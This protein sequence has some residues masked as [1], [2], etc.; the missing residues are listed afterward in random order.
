M[1]TRKKS[2]RSRTRLARRKQTKFL[3]PDLALFPGQ[4]LR[5]V[6]SPDDPLSEAE[7]LRGEFAEMKERH[8]AEE[9]QFLQRI[10]GVAAR[11][12]RR[13]GDF[14]RF[15]VHPFWKQSGQKPKDPS[16][17]KWLLYFIMQATTP[18]AGN[19]A[20]KCA[21]ILDGLMQDKVDDS[22]VAAR[23]EELGGIGAAYAG[24]CEQAVAQPRSSGARRAAWKVSEQSTGVDVGTA[25]ARQ[26]HQDVVDRVFSGRLGIGRQPEGGSFDQGR[27]MVETGGTALPAQTASPQSTSPEFSRQARERP[28]PD[29]SGNAVSSVGRSAPPTPGGRGPPARVEGAAANGTS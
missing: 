25:L 20:D 28:R 19:L 22:A 9:R 14:E 23:I 1:L 6:A 21:V 26:R 2:I 10:Y 24:D 11:F 5:F 3:T 16:T 18:N 7:G 29:P 8:N 17:S 13:P 4:K 15:Q 27:N 12:R